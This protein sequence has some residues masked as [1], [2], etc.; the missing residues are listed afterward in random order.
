MFDIK[1]KDY[2]YIDEK[3]RVHIYYDDGNKASTNYYSWQLGEG[4]ITLLDFDDYKEEITLIYRNLA[5]K[6]ID[7]RRNETKVDS[8]K[9]YEIFIADSKLI[10]EKLDNIAP[11]LHF[12]T[13]VL[14]QY[15]DK[16]LLNGKIYSERLDKLENMTSDTVSAFDMYVGEFKDVINSKN[17]DMLDFEL[18]HNFFNATEEQVAIITRY[19]Y[20]VID[21]FLQDLEFV[22]NNI[23]IE[24]KA[25]LNVVKDSDIENLTTMQRLLLYDGKRSNDDSK[26]RTYIY[27]QPQTILMP[28]YEKYDDINDVMKYEVTYPEEFQNVENEAKFIQENNMTLV[29]MYVIEDFSSLFKFEIINMLN[30]S[31]NIKICENCKRFFIPKNRVDAIYCDRKIGD[32]TKN[33]S[34]IGASRKYN[35]KAKENPIIYL[36]NKTYKRVNRRVH[37][38]KMSVSAFE[39]WSLNASKMRDKALKEK[40]E[41]SEYEEWMNKQ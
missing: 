14:F 11:Y 6:F 1:R 21:V 32:N 39:K 40:I 28:V 20:L 7:I 15:I 29:N 18:N 31:I 22:K 4:I 10:F 19:I 5:D 37:Q 9:K 13:R 34:E 3:D 41:F 30:K 24:I 26:Y 25:L 38:K 36:Y 23:Y 27:F 12:Y 35:Q 8:I 17:K 33:C 2:I 16:I